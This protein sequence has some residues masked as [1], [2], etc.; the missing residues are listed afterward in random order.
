M[1]AAAS[2]QHVWREDLEPDGLL[3]DALV[4]AHHPFRLREDLLHPAGRAQS[5]D[6]LCIVA[7]EQ[8]DGSATTATVQ[9]HID[10]P[11]ACGAT[12][13]PRW[14]LWILRLAL[15]HAARSRASRA[16]PVSASNQPDVVQAHVKAQAARS[17]H[18]I[19]S[20]APAQLSVGP[21]LADAVKV[22][23]ALALQVQELAPFSILPCRRLRLDELQDERAPRDDVG[24]CAMEGVGVGA[25]L[26][27]AGLA[28]RS[29]VLPAPSPASSSQAEHCRLGLA[30][31]AQ[32][33]AAV[34]G[35]WRAA[36][37][38]GHVHEG[39]ASTPRRRWDLQAHRE[40]GSRG[41]PGPPAPSFC[42]W[43]AS[44]RLR[45][46]AD[47]ASHRPTAA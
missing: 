47:R 15:Q 27:W 6:P 23:E 8:A 35:M 45:S 30:D 38:R 34:L 19:A 40:E 18:S 25:G 37:K 21:C 31:D 26:R 33:A 16:G 46:A 17:R 41:P 12:L 2:S 3:R 32:P 20:R 9:E 24:A 10:R 28:Q 14:I 13:L 4:G 43:I 5:R 39:G 29:R 11:P 36:T 1:A 42:R 44:P 7:T 22:V